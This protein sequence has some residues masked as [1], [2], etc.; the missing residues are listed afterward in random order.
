MYQCATDVV[1]LKELLLELGLEDMISLPC[2]IFTDNTGAICI[3]ES[4]AVN[5]K[6]KH[7]RVKY[8]YVR[9]LVRRGEISFKYVKSADNI[10]DLFTKPLSG[11]QTKDFA[12][13]LGIY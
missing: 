4:N 1:W 13:S 11:K 7:I 12:F 2:T 6:T 3:S 5:D 8:H 9:Q 10:A